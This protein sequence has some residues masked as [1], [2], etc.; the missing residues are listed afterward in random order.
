MSDSIHILLQT[1]IPG[2]SDDWHVGRFSLLR[3]HLAALVGEGGVP[4]FRV[5]ARDRAEI[6]FPDPVLSR[7]DSSSYDELWLFAVDVGNGLTPDDI[8]GIERFRQ[9]GGGLLVARDHMD[10]GCSVCGLTGIGPANFFH[11]HNPEPDPSRHTRD[12]REATEILWP[13][14]HSGANGDF[15]EIEIEGALHPALVDP[16]APEGHIRFLPSHPHEG[17]VGAPGGDPKARVIAKGKSKATGRQFNIAVA[18]EASDHYGRALAQSTFH[19]FADSNWDPGM[20]CPSFV[21]EAFG[22]GIASS[23]EARR[24]IRQYV[25]NLAYWLAGRALDGRNFGQR[26]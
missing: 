10:L 16:L 8:D 19:H 18:F 11:S 6:G 9:K 14:Y 15:Q 7:L 24:S 26:V 12:D 3:R 22:S 21:S 4:A 23:P 5:N 13:N 17:A 25:T 2:T 1:T 20:G